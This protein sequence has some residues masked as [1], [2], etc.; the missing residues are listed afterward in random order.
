MKRVNVLSPSKTS[1]RSRGRRRGSPHGQ[2][3][4]SP[5]KKTKQ[6]CLDLLG[7]VRPNPGFSMSYGGKNKKNSRL[8]FL[9]TAEAC[10]RERN[11]SLRFPATSGAPAPTL[12]SSR[13]AGWRGS[14]SVAGPIFSSRLPKQGGR[15]LYYWP[16]SRTGFL[17]IGFVADR[18]LRDDYGPR[19]YPIEIYVADMI[20]SRPSA[21][22]KRARSIFNSKMIFKDG[23]VAVTPR[24]SRWGGWRGIRVRQRQSSVTQREELGSHTA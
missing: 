1:R 8:C 20:F 21:Q 23:G 7:F 15:R 5:A 22:L 4:P 16:V 24:V 9:L 6:N 17:A 10:A 3:A 13:K 11:F 18:L 14:S 19:P 2:I 12:S